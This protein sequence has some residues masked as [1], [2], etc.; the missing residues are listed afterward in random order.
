MESISL[1]WA[2][3][4]RGASGSSSGKC[5]TKE[6]IF[7]S[8]LHGWEAHTKGRGLGALV[9]TRPWVD[10]TWKMPFWVWRSYVVHMLN[11]GPGA[12]SPLPGNLCQGL[13]WK[14]DKEVKNGHFIHPQGEQQKLLQ[15]WLESTDC[16][17]PFKKFERGHYFHDLVTVQRPQPQI[18]SHCGLELQHMNCGET[19]TFSPSQDSRPSPRDILRFIICSYVD[20]TC[21]LN[22]YL[23]VW[24]SIYNNRYGWLIVPLFCFYQLLSQIQFHRHTKQ[25]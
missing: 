16:L 6:S 22:A 13:G 21:S 12:P 10:V 18:P 14:L 24:E 5:R 8:L 2:C 4:P 17:G 9:Q 11:S 25:K 23:A 19:Q 15:Y 1:Q 20:C 7:G 3:T